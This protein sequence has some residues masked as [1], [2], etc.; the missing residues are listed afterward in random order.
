MGH[1]YSDSKG[2]LAVESSESES[3]GCSLRFFT[4]VRGSLGPGTDPKATIGVRS[5]VTYR[6]TGSAGL[7]NMVSV[8][9]VIP[10]AL[11]LISWDLLVL[12]GGGDKLEP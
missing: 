4:G 11:P 1:M 3:V 10:I 6:F 9:G 5:G 7:G 8:A 2:P 12:G